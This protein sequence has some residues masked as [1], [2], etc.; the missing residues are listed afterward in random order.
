M[1]AKLPENII[2]YISKFRLKIAQIIAAKVSACIGA[3]SR[4]SSS[5]GPIYL[6]IYRKRDELGP[7]TRFMTPSTNVESFFDIGQR[8]GRRKQR[9]GI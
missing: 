3:R 8:K 1:N 6:Y 9:V 2:Y 7:K 5:M 4:S